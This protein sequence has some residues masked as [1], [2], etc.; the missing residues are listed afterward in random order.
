M[1]HP[2]L[3]HWSPDGFWFVR[4]GSFAYR[5]MRQRGFWITPDGIRHEIG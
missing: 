5:W 4:L 1:M 3:M 2:D